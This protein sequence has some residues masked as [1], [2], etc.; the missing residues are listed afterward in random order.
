[1]SCR[2]GFCGGCRSCL[3]LQGWSPDDDDYCEHDP[4]RGWN[5]G[6]KCSRCDMMLEEPEED[7]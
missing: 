5:G 7:R 2:D 3:T 4:V 6:V 1:M